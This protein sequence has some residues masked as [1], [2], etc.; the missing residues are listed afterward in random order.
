MKKFFVLAVLFLGTSLGFSQ[1]LDSN[2]DIVEKPTP[3]TKKGQMFVFFGWNR[4]AF[5][6]SDIRFSGNGYN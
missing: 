1:S 3:L 4:A 6:N 5:S 2:T